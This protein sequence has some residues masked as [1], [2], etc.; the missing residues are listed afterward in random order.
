[1]VGPLVTSLGEGGGWNDQD[2]TVGVMGDGVRDA[3]E[4]Q[5]LHRTETARTEDDHVGVD[6][7]RQGKDVGGDVVVPI[8]E[9][10]L[11]NESSGRGSLRAVGGGVGGAFWRA[12][13]VLS[14]G[15]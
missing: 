3:A 9:S 15:R 1:M 6:V 2:G 7:V 10:E 8:D 4:H 11:R 14:S 5:R 12:V 13:S